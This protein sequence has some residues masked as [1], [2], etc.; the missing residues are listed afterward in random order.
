LR[1][2]NQEECNIIYVAIT[3]AKTELVMVV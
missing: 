3:L 1:R 2:Y